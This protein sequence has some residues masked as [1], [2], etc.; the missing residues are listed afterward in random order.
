MIE[1]GTA[2]EATSTST[3]RCARPNHRSASAAVQIW[4]EHREEAQGQGA[5]HDTIEGGTG[6]RRAGVLPVKEL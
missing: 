5:S 6:A 1:K 2:R 3:V 4:D